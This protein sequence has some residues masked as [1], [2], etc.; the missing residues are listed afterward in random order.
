MLRW[1]LGGLAALVVILAVAAY[2]PGAL[3]A[4]KDWDAAQD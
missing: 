4:Y 3:K 1:I 2:G